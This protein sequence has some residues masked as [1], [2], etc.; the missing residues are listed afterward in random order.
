MAVD[1]RRQ[2]AIGLRVLSEDKSSPEMPDL[3]PV[4]GRLVIVNGVIGAL[5]VG[6]I[7]AV[8]GSVIDRK[9]G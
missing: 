8:I 2:P 4:L 5:I 1:A 7:S 6:G 3:G 9:G